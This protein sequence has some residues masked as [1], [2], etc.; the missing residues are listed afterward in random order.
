MTEMLD[1]VAPGESPIVTML[2][3]NRVG[4][5]LI[6]QFRAE[7]APSLR[8]KVPRAYDNQMFSHSA[9]DDPDRLN[10]LERFRNGE[11]LPIR[12]AL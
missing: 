7:H 9:I 2:M 5:R 12:R 10:R 8:G 6:V 4:Q 3:Q 11:A 1:F